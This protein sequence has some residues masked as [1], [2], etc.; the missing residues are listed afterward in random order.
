MRQS[1]APPQQSFSNLPAGTTT[2]TF[3]LPAGVAELQYTPIDPNNPGTLT[4]TLPTDASGTPTTASNSYTL[5][6]QSGLGAFPGLTGSLWFQ[7]IGGSTFTIACTAAVQ[8]I[9]IYLSETQDLL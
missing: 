4:L 5:T 7:T 1:Q 6:L 2:P 8:S 3:T 9:V